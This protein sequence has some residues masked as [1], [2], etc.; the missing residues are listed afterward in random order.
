MKTTI[1]LFAAISLMALAAVASVNQS[2]IT[3]IVAG[4]TSNHRQ[5]ADGSIQA[6]N[7]HFFAE[8]FVQP[9]GKVSDSRLET[10]LSKG[11]GEPFTDSGY[12]LEMHGG[13]YRTEAELEAAYPDG[14]YVSRR[15]SQASQTS[16]IPPGK[17]RRSPI[18]NRSLISTP[19]DTIARH[20]TVSSETKS[21][22]QR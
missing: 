21:P 6:L 12:A 14:D 4:K 8:I 2:D 22:L 10:P 1:T 3:F 15:E 5:Q 13:R 7:Y 19:L 17:P 11:R 18:R 16:P 9:K 20:L